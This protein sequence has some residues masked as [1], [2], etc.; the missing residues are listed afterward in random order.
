MANEEWKTLPD[1]PNYE[2]NWVLHEKPWIR[3]RSKKSQQF[4]PIRGNKKAYYVLLSANKYDLRKD[5]ARVELSVLEAQYP[6]PKP[7]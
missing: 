3:I 2:L 4:Q 5:K 6:P 7:E 1:Y